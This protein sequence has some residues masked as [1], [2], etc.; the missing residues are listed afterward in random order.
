MQAAGGLVIL[1]PH[2]VAKVVGVLLVSGGTVL[3]VEYLINGETVKEEVKLDDDQQK[4]LK[5]VGK[6]TLQD[7][8]GAKK[9]VV[10]QK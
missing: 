1:I 2:P 8:E 6:V 4:K 7:Q 3:V 10:P 9:E 5:E